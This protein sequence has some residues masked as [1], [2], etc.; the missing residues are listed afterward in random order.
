[1]KLFLN[2]VL[3][4]VKVFFGIIGPILQ[5]FRDN[6]NTLKLVDNFECMNVNN[7][8]FIVVDHLKHILIINFEHSALRRYVNFMPNI[9][10]TEMK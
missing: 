2:I 5:L 7:E 9:T 10:E 1:M 6:P 8:R 3:L 4:Q